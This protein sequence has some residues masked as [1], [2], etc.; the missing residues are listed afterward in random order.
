MNREEA[1][2]LAQRIMDADYADDAECDAMI[3]A[4]ERETA[5]PHASDYIFWA[6]EPPP[7][8]EEVADRAMV[9]KPFAL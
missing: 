3:A 6:L 2:H 7:T 8:A 9:Y 1:I 4:L 5:C